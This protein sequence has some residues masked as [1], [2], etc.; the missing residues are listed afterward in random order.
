MISAHWRISGSWKC[1]THLQVCCRGP[2]QCGP[3]AHS[4]GCGLHAQN[5]GKKGHPS[6]KCMPYFAA[7]RLKNDVLSKLCFELKQSEHPG[8]AVVPKSPCLKGFQ[9][10]YTLFT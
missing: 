10:D 4:M 8:L 7:V 6:S 9:K 1:V 3:G 5:D 2:C